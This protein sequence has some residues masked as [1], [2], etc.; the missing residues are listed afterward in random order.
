MNDESR[1]YF[2]KEMKEL[3][4]ILADVNGR[5]NALMREAPWGTGRKRADALRA[6]MDRLGRDL[7]NAMFEA[8]DVAMWDEASYEWRTVSPL[9]DE[10]FP[11]VRRHDGDRR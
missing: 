5:A 4:D 8:R 6:Q 11:D 7:G 9:E 2:R 10:T 1:D 3:T